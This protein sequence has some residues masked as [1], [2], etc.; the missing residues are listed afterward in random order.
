MNSVRFDNVFRRYELSFRAYL[1]IPDLISGP[2]K[3]PQTL[4]L[5]FHFRLKYLNGSPHILQ[6]VIT[7]WRIITL[8]SL[9]GTVMQIEKALINDRLHVSKVP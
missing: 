6:G 3:T 5:P 9:K 8:E 7:F 2:H 1:S 4:H